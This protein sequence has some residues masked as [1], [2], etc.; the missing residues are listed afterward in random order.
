MKVSRKWIEFAHE[1]GAESGQPLAQRLMEIA[2]Q[3]GKGAVEITDP[4]IIAELVDVAE[5]Y[6]NSQY[7]DAVYDMGLWWRSQPRK[8]IE[9]GRR[10]LKKHQEVQKEH[11]ANA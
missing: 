1:P 7:G 5:L 11:G 10:A 9:E 2:E 6:A 8:I 3:P 4:D